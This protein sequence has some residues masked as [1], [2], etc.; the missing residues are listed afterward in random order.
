MALHDP[1][2]GFTINIYQDDDGDYLAHFVEMPNISAFGYSTEIAIA[3]LATAWIGV[4]ESYLQ[5]GETI[6]KVPEWKSNID[7]VNVRMDRQLHHS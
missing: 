2:D 6:P 4:K 7:K 3:E 1:F 5:R